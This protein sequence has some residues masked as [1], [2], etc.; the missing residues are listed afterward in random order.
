MQLRHF[1]MIKTKAMKKNIHIQLLNEGTKVYRP[2]PAFEIEKSVYKI[3]CL[4][5][6]TSGNEE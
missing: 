6:Y 4:E 5:I 1:D 3:E 2:I